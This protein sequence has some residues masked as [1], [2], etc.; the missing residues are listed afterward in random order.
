MDAKK[1]KRK[2]AY[3]SVRKVWARDPKTRVKPDGKAVEKR[4]KCRGKKDPGGDTCAAGRAAHVP[5]PGFSFRP[6]FL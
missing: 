5:P 3:L 4:K 2:P 6:V 1:K